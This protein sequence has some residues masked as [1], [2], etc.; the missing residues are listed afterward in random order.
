MFNEEEKKYYLRQKEKYFI[1]LK[2]F[3]GF[4]KVNKSRCDFYVERLKNEIK[5]TN[6]DNYYLKLIEN[7]NEYIYSGNFSLAESVYILVNFIDP[8]LDMIKIYE[9]YCN[10]DEIIKEIKNEFGFYDHV[11]IKM[12]KIYM[13]KYKDMDDYIF[14]K[15]LELK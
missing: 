11:I 6:D 2:K 5:K 12:E 3:N 14:E 9:T 13:A 10:K 7:L 1:D 8:E 15:N 4:I